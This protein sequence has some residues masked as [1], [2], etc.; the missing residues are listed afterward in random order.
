M[1]Q[2]SEEEQL[3][4]LQH[5]L[6]FH[7]VPHTIHELSSVQLLILYIRTDVDALTKSRAYALVSARSTNAKSNQVKGL[8]RKLLATDLLLTSAVLVLNHSCLNRYSAE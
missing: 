5:P 3:L 6:D 4:L 2:Q 8:D 1:Q 7:F